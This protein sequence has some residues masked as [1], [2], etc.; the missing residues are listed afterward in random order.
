M[1]IF[2]GLVGSGVSE[3]ITCS[4]RLARWV[5]RRNFGGHFPGLGGL[6]GAENLAT[7]PV[8]SENCS[9]TLL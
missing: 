3:Y 4:C 8:G 5:L 2:W 9:K 7:C 6:A 1:S